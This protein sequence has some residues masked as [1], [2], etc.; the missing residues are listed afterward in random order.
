ML[1][2]TMGIHSIK[3]SVEKFSQQMTQFCQQINFKEKKR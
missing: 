3:F 1:N 2:D